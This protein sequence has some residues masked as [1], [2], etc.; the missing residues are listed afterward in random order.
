M[1]DEEI[2]PETP[3][4]PPPKRRPFISLTND[5]IANEILMYQDYELPPAAR[6]RAGIRLLSTAAGILGKKDGKRQLSSKI[7][8]FVKSYKPP[9]ASVT[10]VLTTDGIPVR[11][12]NIGGATNVYT[13]IALTDDPKPFLRMLEE[14]MHEEY[15]NTELVRAV[16]LVMVELAEAG[17][18]PKVVER[19]AFSFEH[20][21]KREGREEQDM[22]YEDISEGEDE[23][24]AGDSE[25]V[26]EIDDSED[27][28]DDSE[29]EEPEPDAQV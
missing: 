4:P 7:M 17:V 19:L 22:K 10:T 1:P 28:E 11:R 21:K 15:Y 24:T 8:R 6:V 27:E 13:D 26:D 25:T 14:Q 9:R 29:D 3:M 18:I 16:S 23:P 20:L 2:P 12:V 5:G